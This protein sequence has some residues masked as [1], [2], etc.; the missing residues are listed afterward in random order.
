MFFKCSAFDN[1]YWFLLAALPQ[2]VELI[3][4]TSQILQRGLLGDCR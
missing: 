2:Q 4:S 3:Y 1:P